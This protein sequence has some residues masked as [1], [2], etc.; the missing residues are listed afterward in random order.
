MAQKIEASLRASGTL[1]KP[2]Q[3]T[4]GELVVRHQSYWNQIKSQHA[5]EDPQKPRTASRTR[6]AKE[7]AS[8]LTPLKY[9]QSN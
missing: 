9:N 1:G 2:Q 7:Q 6:G 4:H 5:Y 8:Y 3:D